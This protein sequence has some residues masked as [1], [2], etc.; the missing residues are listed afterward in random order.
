MTTSLDRTPDASANFAEASGD[1]HL[2]ACSLHLLLAQHGE[3]V[4]LP[5]RWEINGGEVRPIIEHRHPD[6][7]RMAQQIADALELPLHVRRITANDGERLDSYH[8]EGRWG[9]ANWYLSG[10]GL[11]AEGGEPR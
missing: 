4:D 6:G 2:A 3:L 8:A 7:L 1:A 10:F 11:P 9:G 5:A